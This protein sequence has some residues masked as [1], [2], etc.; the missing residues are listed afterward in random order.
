[1]ILGA[2][3]FS[4]GGGSPWV[5]VPA[6]MVVPAALIALAAGPGVRWAAAALAALLLGGAASMLGLAGGERIGGLPGSAWAMFGAFWVVPLIVTVG[7]YA[8]S[9]R[10]PEPPP[11][12]RAR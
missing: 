8:A 1:V 12:R 4:G 10:D 11:G 9:F 2:L 3:L 7:A 5:F 6:A